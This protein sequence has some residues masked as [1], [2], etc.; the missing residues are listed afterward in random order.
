MKV[1]WFVRIL[2][3]LLA[4]GLASNS[5]AGGMS[6]AKPMQQSAVFTAQDSLPMP[7]GMPNGANCCL[8]SGLCLVGNG[9]GCGSGFALLAKTGWSLAVPSAAKPD[10]PDT[11]PLMTQLTLAPFM[12]PPRV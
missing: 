12:R 11:A 2:F 10:M 3:L 1:S 8:T 9:A 4:L 7:T 6:A 5:F